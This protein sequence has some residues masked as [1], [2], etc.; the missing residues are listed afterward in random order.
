MLDAIREQIPMEPT[1]FK[2]SSRGQVC[3][4]CSTFIT[5]TSTVVKLHQPEAPNTIDGRFDATTGLPYYS[6]GRRIDVRARWYVH[7]RC[8]LKGRPIPQV[9]KLARISA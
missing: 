8:W 5:S 6:S 1:P 4:R 7:E 3:P 9:A 2:W